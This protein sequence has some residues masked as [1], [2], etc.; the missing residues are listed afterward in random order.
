MVERG[1]GRRAQ[2]PT[3]ASGIVDPRVRA[4]AKQ[5][6]DLVRGCTP[7]HSLNPKQHLADYAL[8][9]NIIRRLMK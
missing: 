1:L 7:E 8:A 3:V 9:E 6:V 4:A 2:P 5:I